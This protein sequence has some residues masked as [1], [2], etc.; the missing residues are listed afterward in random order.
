MSN[1]RNKLE[2]II[3]FKVPWHWI[4]VAI[5]GAA[6]LF[7]IFGF[8]GRY[9]WFF[10]IFANFRPQYAV[11]ALLSAISLSFSKKFVKFAIFAYM[12]FIVICVYV[13]PI[14]LSPSIDAEALP[15][16]HL[17]VMQINV[18][19]AN[20]EYKKIEDEILQ[21]DPDIVLLDEVNWQW[22]H[23]LS[24]I[25]AKYPY[26]IEEP[27]DDNFGIAMF[28]KI[29]PEKCEIRI[30]RVAQVPYIYA[31]FVIDPQSRKSVSFFGLHTL[32]PVGKENYETR[33][34]QLA[35]I[36]EDVKKE[37][38][39]NIILTGDLNLT[40]W[41]YFYQKL[42]LDAGLR[43]SQQGFG[44]QPTWPDKMFFLLIPLDHCLV[45]P[46]IRVRNRRVGRNV[47]SD[48]YPL[49]VDLEI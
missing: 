20:S 6:L 2:A 44:V 48:H 16:V 9:A 42:E 31:K 49:I 1:N 37:Q 41:S 3:K 38:A 40:P 8:L 17:R 36:A 11:V 45:S 35:E 39:E 22:L 46:A 15:G 29:K 34:A 33:N 26:R 10:D 18:L 32:P 5:S 4:P 43:N 27:R 30:S 14:Y 21:N 12:S 23:N 25:K 24:G 28:A 7:L 13:L 19:S 47:G